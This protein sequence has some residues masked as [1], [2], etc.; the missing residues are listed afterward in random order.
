MKC[1]I[2]KI[3]QNKQTKKKSERKWEWFLPSG[4]WSSSL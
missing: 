2:L 4:Y 3:K 1:I